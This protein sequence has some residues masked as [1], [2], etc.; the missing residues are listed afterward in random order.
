MALLIEE[1]VDTAALITRDVVAAY[2]VRR[3]RV[4]TSAL[5]DLVAGSVAADLS[6]ITAV[7]VAEPRVVE[8][9]T[10]DH[11]DLEL[12]ASATWIL[13]GR[14]WD[15]VVLVPCH[16]IGDAHASLRAAPC[17]IQP[18]WFDEDGTWFGALETP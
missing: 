11:L 14:G 1:T 5:G 12:L 10:D 17:H 2:T 13:A 9:I 18:W 15:V 3:E 4:T 7:V 16:R 8:I 6:G